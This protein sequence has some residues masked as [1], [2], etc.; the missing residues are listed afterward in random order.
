MTSN[1]IVTTRE[2]LVQKIE[3]LDDSKNKVEFD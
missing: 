2:Y 1:S 3:M